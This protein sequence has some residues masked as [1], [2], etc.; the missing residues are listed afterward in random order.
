[1][2]L[3]HHA[4]QAANLARMWPT[5]GRTAG[6]RLAAVFGIPASIL[7]LARILAESERNQ[8]TGE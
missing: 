2:T 6:N 7:T 4:R 3:H 5:L 8:I 1:M